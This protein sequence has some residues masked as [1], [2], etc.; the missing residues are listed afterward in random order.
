MR[1]FAGR[2]SSG[3]ERGMGQ[4]GP[5]KDRGLMPDMMQQ[6]EQGWVQSPGVRGPAL[7]SK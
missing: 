3:T 5:M 7:L 2:S 4:R 1:T 6:A